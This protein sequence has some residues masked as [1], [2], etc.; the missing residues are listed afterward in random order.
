MAK[1]QTSEQEMNEQL[2]YLKRKEKLVAEAN[3]LVQREVYLA[4]EIELQQ[5][6]SDPALHPA[7]QPIIDNHKKELKDLALGERGSEIMT[8]EGLLPH[9][10]PI[11]P[12]V[13]VEADAVHLDVAAVTKFA[14]SGQFRRKDQLCTSTQT[15]LLNVHA[16]IDVSSVHSVP[17]R[18]V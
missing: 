18:K 16:A 11:R 5:R 2:Q 6:G 12:H 13:Q 7:T 3:A 4:E 9:G 8:E 14:P 10:V 1:F 17:K 15:A